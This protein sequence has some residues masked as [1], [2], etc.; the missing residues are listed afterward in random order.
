MPF[1]IATL[2]LQ[3]WIQMV[4][5][6]ERVRELGYTACRVPQR[7]AAIKHSVGHTRQI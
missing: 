4:S 3:Q 7:L 5:G 6:Q 1:P 2:L